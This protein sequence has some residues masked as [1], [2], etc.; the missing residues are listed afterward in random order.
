MQSLYL[1]GTYGGNERNSGPS[2]PYYKI[3]SVPW[4]LYSLANIWHGATVGFAG[5]IRSLSSQ[6]RTRWLSRRGALKRVDVPVT[7]SGVFVLI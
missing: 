5:H 2:F 7:F 4:L 3:Q 6:C 1:T